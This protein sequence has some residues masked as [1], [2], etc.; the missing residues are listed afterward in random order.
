LRFWGVDFKSAGETAPRQTKRR[1]GQSR[2]FSP[3]PDKSTKNSVRGPFAGPVDRVAGKTK[4]AFRRQMATFSGS[5]SQE[6]TA[7]PIKFYGNSK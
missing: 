4:L 1:T 5:P 2:F 3:L 7:Q 6:K